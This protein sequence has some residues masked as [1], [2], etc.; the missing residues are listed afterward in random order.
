M[1]PHQFFF[2]HPSASTA[3]SILARYRP[4]S[5]QHPVCGGARTS[6][7]TSASTPVRSR[8]P[9]Q[10]LLLRRRQGRCV[11]FVDLLSTASKI[12]LRV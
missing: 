8:T 9:R 12:P 10:H 6:A 1:L 3:S 4:R 5:C 2:Q 11:D 7:R